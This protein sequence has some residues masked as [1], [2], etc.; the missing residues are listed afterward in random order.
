MT[1]R[2]S[3]DEKETIKIYMWEEKEIVKMKKRR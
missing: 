3:K 2:N 1:K